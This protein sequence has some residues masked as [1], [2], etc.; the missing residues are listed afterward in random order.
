MSCKKTSQ[1][2]R[3]DF[4]CLFLGVSRAHEY[5]KNFFRSN[6]EFIPYFYT[7]SLKEGCNCSISFLSKSLPLSQDWVFPLKLLS[8]NQRSLQADYMQLT[9]LG[10]FWYKATTKLV[11]MISMLHMKDLYIQ[12]LIKLSQ[13]DFSNNEPRKELYREW[14]FL[15]N[16]SWSSPSPLVNLASSQHLRPVLV[17]QVRGLTSIV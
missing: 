16:F 13:I 12:H 11:K 14:T 17:Q 8:V 4:L 6:M 1:P 5:R 15:R 9:L 7:L 3:T 10:V 2:L